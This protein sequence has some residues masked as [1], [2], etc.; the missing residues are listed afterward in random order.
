MSRDRLR[1]LLRF[2]ATRMS[3]PS[4][5]V[6]LIGGGATAAGYVIAPERLAGI[7]TA[8]VTIVSLIAFV[9]DE[10]AAADRKI[11]ARE[12]GAGDASEAK[13]ESSPPQG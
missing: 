10:D 2:F 1:K 3:Q 7:A 4:S 8:V 11:A 9:F 6:G 5:W 12:A 13:V